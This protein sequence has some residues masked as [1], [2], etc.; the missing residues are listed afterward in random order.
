MSVDEVWDDFRAA[1]TMSPEALEDWLAT[2]ESKAAG[3]KP[4]IRRN[5]D[6]LR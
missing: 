3:Q 6:E 2:D 1:V 5:A 4:T